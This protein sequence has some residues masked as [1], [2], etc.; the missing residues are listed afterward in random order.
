[1]RKH[2]GEKGFTL[3]ELAVVIVVIGIMIGAVLKGQ[4]MIEDAKS[5]R[6]VNDLQGISAAYFAYYDK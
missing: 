4:A 5:K 2:S 6:L 1:M 3:V